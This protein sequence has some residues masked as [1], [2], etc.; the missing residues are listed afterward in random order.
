MANTRRDEHR[1]LL[2]R[3]EQLRKATADLSID[4]TPFDQAEH[5]KLSAALKQ[6]QADLAAHHKTLED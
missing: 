3:T 2:E 1:R 5:D 6:H 4:L